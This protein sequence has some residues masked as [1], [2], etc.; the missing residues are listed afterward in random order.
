[1]SNRSVPKLEVDGLLLLDKSQGYSSNAVLQRVKR[2]Y[3]AKKAG[4]TGSLDPLAT[5]MLPI[6]FGEATKFSAYLLEAD[7]CYEAVG[8]LGIK[9]NTADA[10]GEII[11]RIDRFDIAEEQLVETLSG[12]LGKSFQLP[13]MYSALKHQGRPLYTYARKGIEIDRP[14][15]EIDI[16]SLQLI[17]FD[18]IF[19]KI[20]VICSK[21]TYIR[22]LVEDIGEQLGVG[23]HVTVLHRL[24]TSGFEQDL[25]YSYETLESLSEQERASLLMPVD[26]L[27]SQFPAITFSEPDLIALYQGRD[28]DTEQS[29]AQGLFRLYDQ[30]LNFYGLGLLDV[31]GR[32]HAKRL[33]VKKW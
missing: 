4:H 20:R 33:I 17:D 5:G 21:G 22:N 1:M 24:Y 23:A 2:L 27:V 26:R 12:F 25:M 7:K 10:T 31:E 32:M 19:F 8:Q 14:A 9:T 6:C 18:G 30:G 3:Q 13:S 28:V 16:K 29:G 15:R 11:S